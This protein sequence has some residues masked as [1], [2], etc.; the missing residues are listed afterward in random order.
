MLRPSA[1]MEIRLTDRQAKTY[2]I[3]TISGT[4]ILLVSLICIIMKKTTRFHKK[5]GSILDR[6]ANSVLKLDS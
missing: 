3:N 1:C 5:V 6:L 2:G 4:L